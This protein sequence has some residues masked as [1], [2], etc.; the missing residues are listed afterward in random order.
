MPPDI[1]KSLDPSSPDYDELNALAENLKHSAQSP[2]KRASTVEGGGR[3]RAGT[4]DGDGVAGAEFDALALVWAPCVPVAG[5]GYKVWRPEH[6]DESTRDVQTATTSTNDLGNLGWLNVSKRGLEASSVV[7]DGVERV[8]AVTASDVDVAR[9]K[10]LWSRVPHIALGMIAR[11]TEI[12]PGIEVQSIAWL[13]KLFTSDLEKVPL[14]V[15]MG[16]GEVEMFKAVYGWRQSHL[17]P[18]QHQAH[19]RSLI[20]RAFPAR[21]ATIDDH[22]R[23]ASTYALHHLIP[24]LRQSQVRSACRVQTR[25]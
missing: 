3:R 12:A 18:S 25:F 19:S 2:A 22:V 6:D 10:D 20:K 9:V 15:A 21:R 1:K 13:G 7:T 23:A 11:T 4:S 5:D 16:P 24:P 17:G 14:E 8:C